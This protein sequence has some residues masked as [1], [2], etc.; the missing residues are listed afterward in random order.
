MICKCV[1][2]TFLIDLLRDEEGA[3]EKA[4]ELDEFG[5]TVT[6][7]IN[8]FEVVF[9]IYLSRSV[10]RKKRLKEV[11]MLFDRLNIF[12]FDHASAIKAG[13]ILGELV[14]KGMGI[15]SLDG[16]VAAIALTQGCN[17]IVTRNVKH[18]ERIEGIEVEEY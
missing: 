13:E 12:P 15:D 18:F 14:R 7:E 17:V 1:D 4:E 11:E 16:M 3:V 6:T 8:V 9:G 5:E 2:T 10:N